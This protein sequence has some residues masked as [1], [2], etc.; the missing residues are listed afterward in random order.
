MFREQNAGWKKKMLTLKI[1]LFAVRPTIFQLVVQK[2]GLRHVQHRKQVASIKSEVRKYATTPKI[3][4]TTSL[5]NQSSVPVRVQ[6]GFAQ[7]K[8]G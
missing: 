5:A 3:H 6:L 2:R 1:N 4:N 7:N 8:G